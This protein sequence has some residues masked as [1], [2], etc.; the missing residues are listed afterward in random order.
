MFHTSACIDF[1]F[2]APLDEVLIL[3]GTDFSSFVEDKLIVALW[4]NFST[5]CS[6]PLVYLSIFVAAPACVDYNYPVVYL[7]LCWDASGLVICLC[8]LKFALLLEVSRASMWIFKIREECGWCFDWDHTEYVNCFGYYGQFDD[9][10]SSSPQTWKIL[11]PFMF[12]K[13]H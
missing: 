11:F 5:F 12:C 6:V 9:V 10:K 7:E 2:T 13:L 1:I 3:L 4:I 8:H